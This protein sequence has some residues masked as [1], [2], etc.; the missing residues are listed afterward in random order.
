MGDLVLSDVATITA[1]ADRERFRLFGHVQRNGPVRE[2]TL[3]DELKVGESELETSLS[4]LAAA[5]LVAQSPSGWTAPGRGLYIDAVAG[6]EQAVRR[7]YG[8]MISSTTDLPERWVRDE[9]PRL[10]DRWFAASGM[11]NARVQVTSD[12]LDAIQ[13]QLDA[14]LSPYLT[15]EE[16]PADV[17]QVRVLAYFMTQPD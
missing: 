5:G 8:V 12:E 11:F 15:R 17:K 3:V 14:L 13:V 4:T 2:E 16:L 6:A 1:L 7:L 10:D 9:A